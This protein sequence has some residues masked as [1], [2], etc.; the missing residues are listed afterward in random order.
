MWRKS[1]SDGRPLRSACPN[2]SNTSATPRCTFTGCNSESA[3]QR[4]PHGWRNCGKGWPRD[5]TVSGERCREERT[6]PA[7][8]RRRD[9]RRTA[10]S[11]R[12]ND[13]A[14]RSG[15]PT[16]SSENIGRRSPSSTRTA[17]TATRSWR[18][19]ARNWKPRATR[20]RPVRSFSFPA[21]RPLKSTDA[22]DLENRAREREKLKSGGDLSNTF[23]GGSA[24]VDFV[25]Q[26]RPPP[27]RSRGAR[28]PRHQPRP[29]HV[30]AP[31][32]QVPRKRRK[33][34]CPPALPRP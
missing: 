17:P 24:D 15:T 4:P 20:S 22:T 11:C 21:E 27:R 34:P 8:V 14:R 1:C 16:L 28:R 30:R 7:N 3:R 6:P 29:A 12:R 2:P 31:R 25:T 10:R 26:T 33:T 32:L 5:G 18:S 19:G 13:G 9:Q 23:P